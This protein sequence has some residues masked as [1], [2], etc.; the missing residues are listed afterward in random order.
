MT[1]QTDAAVRDA[2]KHPPALE[3]ARSLARFANSEGGGLAGFE[4][5][6]TAD[7]A[8][9]LVD[10]IHDFS[11]LVSQEGLPQLEADM[12]TAR[13]ANDPWI[14][15]NNFTFYGLKTAPKRFLS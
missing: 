12:V 10:W 6:L 4:V 3:K 13:R 2:L 11:G 7:E 15:L 9:D 5:T 8:F 14:V 1:Q